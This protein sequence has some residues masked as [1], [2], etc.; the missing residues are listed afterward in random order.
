MSV[1]DSHK[2][3][4]NVTMPFFFFRKRGNPIREVPVRH[5]GDCQEVAQGQARVRGGV[6]RLPGL[7][8]KVQGGQH[9]K[10]NC[11]SKNRHF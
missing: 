9:V 6:Q 2:F 7:H 11:S 10:E 8:H 3:S 1:L 4:F 5:A